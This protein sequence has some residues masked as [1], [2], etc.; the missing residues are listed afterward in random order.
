[1]RSD[2]RRIVAV[3]AFRRATGRCPTMIHSLGTGES[4]EI[5]PTAAGFVDV[6]SGRAA[7]A[8]G[9]HIVL[10]GGEPSIDIAFDGDVTFRGFDPGSGERFTG[11]TGGG[12]SVT[13]Y[14]AEGIAY[15]QYAVVA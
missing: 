11:R 6:A 10:S 7:R 14:D 2:T 5:E 15:F 12:A 8:E 1:M 3:D 4:F 9:A 13:V